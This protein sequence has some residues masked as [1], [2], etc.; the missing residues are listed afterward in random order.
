MIFTKA[1]HAKQWDDL[2][3]TT[4]QKIRDADIRA[5]KPKLQP[6]AMMRT[7]FTPSINLAT[8]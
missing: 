2:I 5:T 8:M 7:E 6:G 4:K 3:A 1:E